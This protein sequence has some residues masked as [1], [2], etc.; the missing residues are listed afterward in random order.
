MDFKMTPIDKVKECLSST[1]S[2]V[3]QGGAGSGKTETLKEL[4]AFVAKNN[5]NKSLICITHTNKAVEEINSRIA[6]AFP[7]STIHAFLHSLISSF[8]IDIHRIIFEIFKIER[9]N[10]GKVDDCLS[11][12]EFLENEFV[13]FKDRY[14]KYS[15]RKYDFDQTK[16]PKHIGK[17]KYD[18]D[19]A[20]Y[21]LELNRNIDL[22]NASLSTAIA[23][24]D[25]YSIKYSQKK[26]D[27][28][29]NLSYGH[30]SLIKIAVLLLRSSSVLRKVV[31]DKYDYV[32]IDEYQDTSPEII[33]V[34]LTKMTTEKNFLVGLFGDSMQGIYD[35]GV[36]DVEQ[37][38][39]NGT[40]LKIEKEDNFRCSKQVVDFLNPLRLDGMGQ[41]VSFKKK[42]DGTFESLLERQGR[43]CCYYA[44]YEDKPHAHST[45]E[46]K[47]KYA[48]ALN[49]LIEKAG[50]AVNQKMLVLTNKAIAADAGFKD[51]FSVFYDRYSTDLREQI[52]KTLELLQ[53]DEM[54]ELCKLFGENRYNEI[55]SI[56]RKNNFHILK[57]P[58]KVE[59]FEYLK[60]ISS[61]KLS[62]IKVLN[63][64]FGK[65]ILIRAES[66]EDY[67]TYSNN[68]LSELNCDVQYIKFKSDYQ[69]GANTVS[70]MIEAEIEMDEYLFSEQKNKLERETFLNR[71]LSDEIPFS[72]VLNYFDYLS[73]NKNYITMHKTKGTGIENVLVV[74]EEYFWNKYNF[75]D[76]FLP[77]NT[78]DSSDPRNRKLIYVACSRAK[79]NLTCVR[80]ISARE[81]DSMISA[82]PEVI[83]VPIEELC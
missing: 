72:N 59:L 1:Q 25:P 75:T 63:S 15:R 43:V 52:E 34:L 71:L 73:E 12:K 50:G 64:A 22:L 74:L 79:K 6:G 11:V 32:F 37:Y 56:L 20:T 13:K 58:D 42:L 61:S 51:L 70:R 29:R 78:D 48:R 46:V 77:S 68:F 44:I 80:L 28:Y 62:A 67:L 8:K 47:E 14:T 35:D 9:F 30:D 3:L 81:E 2:F 26:F 55:I 69:R 54:V 16:T 49:K 33:D 38:I 57:Q 7:V 83:K 27:S 40:L 41:E 53:L 31:A 18:K 45:R 23:A 24:T 4:L 36:G 5:A 82:F 39:A 17:V 60:E 19:R 21:N 65:R 10:E 66:H 76:V